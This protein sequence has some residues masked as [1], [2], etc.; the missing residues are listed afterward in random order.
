MR[1]APQRLHETVAVEPAL[2]AF[3]ECT[4]REI[5][6]VQPRKARAQTR[7]IE[8]RDIRAEFALHRVVLAQGGFAA[9]RG[10][11]QIAT[12]VQIDGRP[13]AD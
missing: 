4:R 1:L 10:E 5:V 2:A 12:F 13:F 11:K 3:A 6:R 7:C 9:R 8:Q